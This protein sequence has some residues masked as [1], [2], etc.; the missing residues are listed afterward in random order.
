MELETLAQLYAA[1][2]IKKA[3]AQSVAESLYNIMDVSVRDD[4]TVEQ[5]TTKK[6][7]ERIIKIMSE[8]DEEYTAEITEEYLRIT[9]ELIKEGM[10]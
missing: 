1:E 5:E 8:H 9:I 4:S 7:L 3:D 2:Y 10:K 6:F